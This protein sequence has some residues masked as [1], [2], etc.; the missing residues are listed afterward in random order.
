MHWRHRTGGPSL[1]LG[2]ALRLAGFQFLQ[3][4]FELL[5]LPA[6][7]LGRAAKPHAAQ[8]GKLELECLDLQRLVL[9]RDPR[10]LQLALAGQGKG[11]QFSRI[12]GQG[13]RGER[14]A[15]P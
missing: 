2:R 1:D 4:Q 7:P 10:R 11:A 14:H 13:G 3:P 9:H 5:D 6:D 8:F 12:G 15:K